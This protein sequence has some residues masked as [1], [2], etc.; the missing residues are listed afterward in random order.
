MMWCGINLHWAYTDLLS[1]IKF[2]VSCPHVA[3]DILHDAF[4]RYTVSASPHKEEEPHAY[5]RS[6]ARNLIVDAYHN[7]Q[8]FLSLEADIGLNREWLDAPALS[9]E[10]LN[11]IRQ[12]LEMIQQILEQLPPRCRQVFWMYRVEGYTHPEI[13]V[14]LG[15]SKNMVERH[16]MRAILDLSGARELISE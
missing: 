11:D 10:Q 1:Y 6:I 16:V 8:R 4:I 12:R 14:K 2:K 5:M 3:K 9:V 13:A 7:S 15:I